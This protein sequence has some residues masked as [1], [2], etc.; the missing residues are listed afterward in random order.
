MCETLIGGSTHWDP[1][2]LKLEMRLRHERLVRDQLAGEEQGLLA[3]VL[4][5]VWVLPSVES[6]QVYHRRSKKYT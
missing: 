6:E 2:F 1:Q 5:E 3:V 4:E